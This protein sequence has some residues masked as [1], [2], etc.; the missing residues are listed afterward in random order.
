MIIFSSSIAAQMVQKSILSEEFLASLP[1]GERS[2]LEGNNPAQEE[3]DL[4]KLLRSETSVEKNEAILERLKQEIDE[5]ESKMRSGRNNV[6]DDKKELQRFGEGFFRS[7]QSSFMP[8]NLPNLSSDYI[9]DVGDVFELMLT[10]KL[11]ENHKLVVQRD[12][13]III[14][15]FG[16]V[17]VAGKSVA[18]AEQ[19]VSAFIEKT[20]IGVSNYL[21]LKEIRDVQI[22][23]V[24]SVESPGIYTVSGNSNVLHVLNVAGGIAENG[25]YRRIE[26]RRQGELIETI[27]LYDVFI[28][29]KFIYKADL[30]SG[31]T[32][33]VSPSSFTIP[34]TG[35]IGREAIYEI[36]PDENL[37]D[38]I[39]FAGGFSAGFHGYEDIFVN[40][41][42]ISNQSVLK[43]NIEG[44]DTLELEPRDSVIVPSYQNIAENIKYV[45]LEGMVFRPG[46]YFID[47]DTT[48]SDLINRAGGYKEGAYP[49]GAGLFRADA[50]S[51]ELIFAERNYSDTVNYIVSNIGQ[52][53]SNINSDALSLLIEELKSKRYTGRIITEF[54][55]NNLSENP[56]RDIRLQHTDRIVIPQI[57]KVVY[58]FG[59]FKNPSILNY[60]PNLSISDY[61]ELAGGINDSA[62][63]DIIVI[64]PDG[65]TSS[66]GTSYNFFKYGAP[67]IYPGTII[68]AP[69]QVGQLSGVLYA[70]TVAPVLSSLAISLA[71]LNSISD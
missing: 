50:M 21:S 62:F 41:V 6:L 19:I 42:G 65:K 33:Y 49:Y 45:I 60:D 44:L 11:S 28:S 14:P 48:L 70:S 5:L 37:N 20:Q 25:S 23:L 17:Y 26:H 29:G 35:G 36:L 40:R 8:I 3:E 71:S 66:Y 57:Q 55:L 69:R 68:Y 67:A 47:D 30:R 43:V 59:D 53:N 34:V 16:K 32:I 46:K 22:L 58:L 64:D 9:V 31:D 54:N 38:L 51:K 24:G 1:P 18:Q 12:G 15:D 2:Q 56:G 27:D 10:G 13:A 52:P 39:N 4:E 63:D 61:L 7:I